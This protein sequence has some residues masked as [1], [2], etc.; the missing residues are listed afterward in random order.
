MTTQAGRLGVNIED[1]R[2]VHSTAGGR[3]RLELVVTGAGGA[4]ELT[5]ALEALGYH[6]DHPGIDFST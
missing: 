2:I 6:V 1:L 4:D 3:G 5:M